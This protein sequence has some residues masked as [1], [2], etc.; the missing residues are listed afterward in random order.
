[1]SRWLGVGFML[2]PRLLLC[3]ELRKGCFDCLL[4]Q[5]VSLVRLFRLRLC[6]SHQLDGWLGLG[7]LLG[8]D[9]GVRQRLTVLSFRKYHLLELLMGLDLSVMLG[10]VS[11][12]VHLFVADC[13]LVR[14]L[15]ALNAAL[16][17]TLLLMGILLRLLP[18][19]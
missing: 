11:L 14:A 18:G 2:L 12:R 6:T 3:L 16:S 4:L 15:T 13:R 19:S 5:L 9:H 7:C 10:S 17:R 8:H 1:M